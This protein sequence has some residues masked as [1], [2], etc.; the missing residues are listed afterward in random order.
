MDHAVFDRP[1]DFEMVMY[2]MRRVILRELDKM[3][4]DVRADAEC[5]LE[6]GRPIEFERRFKLEGGTEHARQL[7]L[8]DRE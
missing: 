3:P 4:D 5:A 8:F 1:S 2:D 7:S 6:V